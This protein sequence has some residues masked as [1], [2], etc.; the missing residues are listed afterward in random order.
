MKPITVTP[1][2]KLIDGWLRLKAMEKAMSVDLKI[3]VLDGDSGNSGHSHTVLDFGCNRKFFEILREL[4]P[5]ERPEFT[6]TSYFSPGDKGDLHYGLMTEDCYAKR[7]T[8]LEVGRIVKAYDELPGDFELSEFQTAALE[9][10]GNL[11]ND[12]RV[13]LYWC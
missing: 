8:Y 1:N 9:Y 5:F 3:L 7:L 12:R 4:K 2:M 11:R 10:L 13:C 6:L